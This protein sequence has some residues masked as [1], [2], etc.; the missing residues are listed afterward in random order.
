M[1]VLRVLVIGL[2]GCVAVL[3]AQTRP[4]KHVLAWADVRN[5][6]QRSTWV[7]CLLST[8]SAGRGV[9][10]GWYLVER[11]RVTLRSQ[12]VILC[13]T[14]VAQDGG[15]KRHCFRRTNPVSR[16]TD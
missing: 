1:R 14:G 6:Y 12:F 15:E 13:S 5:G 3:P 10:R 16:S 4:R 11:Y 7:V 9:V 8:L 2:L